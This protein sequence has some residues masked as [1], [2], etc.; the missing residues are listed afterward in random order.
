MNDV[1]NEFDS[2]YCNVKYIQDGNNVFLTWKQ[3]CS[4]EN[5]RVPTTFA[6]DLLKRYPFSNFIVD[7]RNGFEDEKEDVEWGFSF[8]L[9]EMSKAGCKI[10]CFITTENNNIEGEMDLWTAE[11]SKYFIVNRVTSY[12]DAVNLISKQIKR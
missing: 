11:F 12:T 10:V 1:N 7:A 2:I 9:P 5:Y 3:F 8:L 6:L 4:H